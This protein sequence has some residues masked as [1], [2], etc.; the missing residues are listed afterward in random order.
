MRITITI[1]A[2]LALALAGAAAAQ[3]GVKSA[4]K[5]STPAQPPAPTRVE[6]FAYDS[7]TVRCEELLTGKPNRR[8]SATLVLVDE[9]SRAGLLAWVIGKDAE[10]KSVTAVQTPTGV[11]VGKGVDF[12]F[13]N[14]TIY[15]VPYVACDQQHCDA[16]GPIDDAFL[17][18]LSGAGQEAKATITAKDGRAI[19]FKLKILGVDKAL[20]ALRG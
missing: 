4:P 6:T 14:K 17:K 11:A 7:W 8:C 15:K 2:F 5:A 16:S 10:G 13:G 3:T 12:D 19:Q 18:A 20:A 1:S 9:K